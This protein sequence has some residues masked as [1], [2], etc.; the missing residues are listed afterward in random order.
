MIYAGTFN[1][2]SPHIFGV[3]MTIRNEHEGDRPV[4]A[5]FMTFFLLCRKI[6]EAVSV[7]N[8]LLEAELTGLSLLWFTS[9]PQLCCKSSS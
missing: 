4:V 1:P 9:K 7:K 8:Y 6:L 3:I 5:Y 2:I